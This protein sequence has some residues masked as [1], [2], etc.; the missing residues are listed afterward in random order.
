MSY[1]VFWYFYFLSLHSFTWWVLIKYLLGARPRIYHSTENEREEH[2]KKSLQFSSV[3]LLSRVQLFATPWTAARQASLSITNSGSS[4]KPQSI[5]SVMPS[6][7]LILCHPL[8]LLPSIFPSIRVFSNES[9]LCIRWPT[10][11]SFH[12]SISPSKEHPGLIS[13]RMDWLDLLAVQ[14]TLKSLLQHHSSKAS[15]LQRSA[16]FLVQLSHPYMTTGKT[17]ALTRQTFVDN[18]MSLLFN[19]LSRLVIKHVRMWKFCKTLL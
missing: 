13:F 7:H 14:G 6:N 3:Q 1:D 10:Y 18:V 15:I 19:M 17:I 12:F 11:W 16:F 4:P 2:E 5:E 8:L 9:A